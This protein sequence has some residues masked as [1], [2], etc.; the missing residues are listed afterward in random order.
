MQ[1]TLNTN[2]VSDCVLAYVK[3]QLGLDET[4]SFV[5]ELH[6]DGITVLVNEE[7]GANETSSTPA[8]ERPAKKPR[9]S[10]A[11][12][13]A[14][15]KAE[16]ERLAAAGK[17]NDTQTS[18]TSAE[19]A[20][21]T[22]PAQAEAAVDTSPAETEVDPELAQQLAEASAEEDAAADAEV[23]EAQAVE[24]VAEAQV[25]PVVEEEPVR[26]PSTS[27]FANLRKP[28]NG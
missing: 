19:A 2:E 28:N 5:V 12:I 27:L 7:A 23:A 25:E 22:E 21:V 17:S 14:D 11:Q 3:D 1:I 26:K 8:S 24:P 13:E 6:E 15:K 4:N 9:R 20:P 10:K 16:E 18:T